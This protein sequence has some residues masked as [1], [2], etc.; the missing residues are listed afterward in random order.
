MARENKILRHHFSCQ[1][2]ITFKKYLAIGT[3][4][5][6]I[7]YVTISYRELLPIV[8]DATYLGT[9][10]LKAPFNVLEK[11]KMMKLPKD[12]AYFINTI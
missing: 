1:F 11:I 2:L 8:K 5:Q 3:Q 4:T 12:N 7:E 6:R 10:T 9:S